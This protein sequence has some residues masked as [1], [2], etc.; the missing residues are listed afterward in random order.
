MLTY[1]HTDFSQTTILQ[2]HS[3]SMGVK[4]DY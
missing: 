1:F 2:K 3:R 4:N